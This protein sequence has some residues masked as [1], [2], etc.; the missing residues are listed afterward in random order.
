MNL[1]LKTIF[2]VSLLVFSQQIA[3]AQ[4]AKTVTLVV[5]GQGKTQDEAKQNALRSAIEQAFGTFIS[6]KTE[7]LN[8]NLVKDEVVSVANGNI[9]K[10]EVISLIELS[11]CIY[12][13][14]KAQVSVNK[15]TTF[16]ANKG[17][18]IE[19]EGD[20]YAINLKNIEINKSSELKVISNLQ[21]LCSIL[22]P[23][24]FS[25]QINS[26][27]PIFL[28]ENSY[29]VQ[30]TTQSIPNKN[31]QELL[32]FILKTLNSVSLK[33]DEIE[34]LKLFHI[35]SWEIKI[36]DLDGRVNKIV[37]RNSLNDFINYFFS[38]LESQSSKFVIDDGS[39]KLNFHKS[40]REVEIRK[41]AFG[42]L[43]YGVFGNKKQ[44]YDFSLI[45]IDGTSLLET[46]IILNYDLNELKNIK[47][48]KINNGNSGHSKIV[49]PEMLKNRAEIRDTAKYLSPYLLFFTLLI[50]FGR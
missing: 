38:E 31:F 29:L 15:L 48:Y 14:L 16:F 1:I 24:V 45:K 4:E 39:K 27:P 43:K 2:I 41:S 8:D 22:I 12:I 13:S 50:I 9:Q 23:K 49:S 42:L 17:F 20:K 35:P 33:S 32:N 36:K 46:K 18:K 7:I 28:K 34:T 21:D 44:F 37:S 3:F 19:F 10:Y 5:S 25:Y 11:N 26:I 30:I 47:E 6:S 40:S